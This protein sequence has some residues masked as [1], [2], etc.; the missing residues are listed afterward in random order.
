MLNAGK[1]IC[2]EFVFRAQ[3][4]HGFVWFSTLP[5]MFAAEV[6]LEAYPAS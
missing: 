2:G 4:K 5:G 3:Y 1:G 6:V